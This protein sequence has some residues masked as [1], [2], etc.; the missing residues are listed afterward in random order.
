MFT[1]L[2]YVACVV[3]MA[4]SGAASDDGMATTAAAVGLE[5]EAAASSATTQR[6][7]PPTLQSTDGKVVAEILA[8]HE[9]YKKIRAKHN[10]YL[11]QKHL[12]KQRAVKKVQ[13]HHQHA[14][15]MQENGHHGHTHER[16]FHTQNLLIIPFGT[17]I[18]ADIHMN[19]HFHER[20]LSHESLKELTKCQMLQHRK[21]GGNPVGGHTS[22]RRLTQQAAKECRTKYE[23]CIDHALEPHYKTMDDR[24]NGPIDELV[25]RRA[26]QHCDHVSSVEKHLLASHRKNFMDHYDGSS[27]HHGRGLKAP[28]QLQNPQVFHGLVPHSEFIEPY[29]TKM[30]PLDD[31]HSSEMR[32]CMQH[33]LTHKEWHDEHG[34][35]NPYSF[36]LAEI[37]CHH[38]LHGFYDREHAHL[39]LESTAGAG[40]REPPHT[41][42]PLHLTEIHKRHRAN[43]RRLAIKAAK[44]TDL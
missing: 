28:M 10:A 8:E 25:I 17:K 29:L 16:D 30:F 32:H 14:L 23:T 42:P 44:A 13:E 9:E 40:L 38:D 3:L 27:N 22:V 12:F 41:A 5:M 11:H 43:E 33:K 26:A 7:A 37:H 2:T 20:F 21:K 15:V 19:H 6:R 1:M 35:S 39:S 24:V 36:R 34:A 18:N 31:Y 4:I